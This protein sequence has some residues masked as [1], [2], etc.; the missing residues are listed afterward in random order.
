MKKKLR[1]YFTYSGHDYA[2]MVT[3]PIFESQYLSQP[4]GT[5]PIGRALI[6]VSLGE[7]YRGHAYKLIAG[8]VLPS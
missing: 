2:M 8:I 6:C 1:G 3:D 7:P 4:E 5:F